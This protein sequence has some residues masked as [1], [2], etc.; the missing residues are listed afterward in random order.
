MAKWPKI[1]AKSKYKV[2]VSHSGEDRWAAEQIERLIHEAG[3][4]TFLDVRDIQAGSNFK[5]RIRTEI[6]GCHELVALFTPW[7]RTRPWVRHEMGMADA[8][9]RRVVCVFY[10]VTQSDFTED[11]G[12]GPLDGLNIVDINSFDRYLSELK[13]RMTRFRAKQQQ[14]K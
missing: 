5:D 9:R 7:S 6:E 4:E 14:K 1:S 3:A 2:F 13:K 12:L 10:K 8:R 11:G